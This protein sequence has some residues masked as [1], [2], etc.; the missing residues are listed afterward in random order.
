MSNIWYWLT[1][2]GPLRAFDCM[3][4]WVVVGWLASHTL[5]WVVVELCR[6]YQSTRL[7]IRRIFQQDVAEE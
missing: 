7:K 2:S 3:V 4:Q 1:G 5:S 6:L